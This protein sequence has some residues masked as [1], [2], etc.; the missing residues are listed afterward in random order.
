MN[1]NCVS[2][3]ATIPEGRQVCPNCEKVK[4][5]YHFSIDVEK[6]IKSPLGL[7]GC[8]TTDGKTLNTAAEVR[9]FLRG[10]LAL[11]R[12]Y[13]PCGDCDNF[14]YQT[15]CKGHPKKEVESGKAN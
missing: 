15:G 7:R 1:N 2:C 8:I 3:G 6:G 12:K 9:E 13:L 5:R 14:D 4:T 11:G 10:Q